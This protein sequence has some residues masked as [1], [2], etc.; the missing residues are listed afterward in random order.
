MLS[1][2]QMWN[3]AR[4]ISGYGPKSILIIISHRLKHIEKK[5]VGLQVVY[6]CKKLDIVSLRLVRLLDA[7][8]PSTKIIY[9]DVLGRHLI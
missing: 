9:Q 3:L 6:T 5:E 4:N 2:P 1:I 7:G 8:N